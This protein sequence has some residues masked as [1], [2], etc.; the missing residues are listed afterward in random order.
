MDS[1]SHKSP[2]KKQKGECTQRDVVCLLDHKT[3]EEY[4]E[5]DESTIFTHPHL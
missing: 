2:L 1:I 3:S 5:T 4:L